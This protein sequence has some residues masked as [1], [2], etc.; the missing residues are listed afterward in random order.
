M[1]IIWLL[2][3]I[4]RKSAIL[5][6]T[7]NAFL[8]AR[9]S[10]YFCVYGLRVKGLFSC[11][12]SRILQLLL[13]WIDRYA[14][15]SFCN[16]EQLAIS[17]LKFRVRNSRDSLFARDRSRLESIQSIRRRRCAILLRSIEVFAMLQIW[18]VHHFTSFF[19]VSR[20]GTGITR[21]TGVEGI[22]SS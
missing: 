9:I 7:G 13:T 22:L 10:L 18:I 21:D 4:S 11:S 1:T 14:H 12:Y 20:L 6:C 8:L 15:E 17:F 5:A 3:N 2:L 19:A 16:S